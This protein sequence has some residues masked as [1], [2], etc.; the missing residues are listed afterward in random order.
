[1]NLEL[2]EEINALRDD[3][4]TYTEIAELTGIAR[5]SIVLSLRLS[6]IFNTSHAQQISS[7]NSD[8]ELLK[9]TIKKHRDSFFE[10]DAEIKRLH[11]LIDI[12]YNRD[13]LIKKTEFKNLQDELVKSKN[14]VDMLNRKLRYQNTYFKNL[15]FV[16]K[17]KILF[18]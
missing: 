4:K 5:T 10:K 15:S 2:L 18:N 1:M 14:E 12:D 11:S 3:K 16:E 7:L 13:M 17:M 8:I 6:K 9:S